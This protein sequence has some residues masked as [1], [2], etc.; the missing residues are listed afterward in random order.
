MF[1]TSFLFASLVWGSVGVGYFIYGKK[2]SSW[3]PMVGGVLIIAISYFVASALLMSL[4]CLALIA[5]VYLVLK[6]GY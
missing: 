1:N 3:A 4:L 6:Q 2:Q 5:G